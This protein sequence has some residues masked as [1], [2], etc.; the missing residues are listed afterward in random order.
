MKLGVV[1]RE[2]VE[3]ERELPAEDQPI[4]RIEP[5]TAGPAAVR[6]LRLRR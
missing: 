5:R 1:E 6:R 4:D 2:E 3:V